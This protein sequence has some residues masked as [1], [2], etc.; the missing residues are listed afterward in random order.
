MSTHPDDPMMI[1]HIDMNFVCLKEDYIRKWLRTLAEMGYNAVLWELEDKVRWETCPECV[2]PEAFPK[3]T[4]RDLLAYSRALG[5]EPIPLLQTIGHAEYVL[6]HEPYRRFREQP[7]RHDCYC[8][9]NPEVRRFL[10]AWIE[11]YLDLFGDLRYFHLG[12]DEAYVFG[13]CPDCRAYTD[14]HSPNHLY[15]D[16]IID[17]AEPIR[18]RGIRPG[19]W[20]DMVLAHPEHIDA[21]PQAFVIWDWNYWSTGADDEGTRL[22]DEGWVTLNT[23]T[24]GQTKR[25]PE[26]LDARGRLRPFYTSDVLQ[27]LGYDVILCSAARSAGDTAFLPNYPRHV[28]NIATAA[29]KART[30]GLL[31]NC[32]TSWAVRLNPYET[33]AL[34][35]GLA[36][37]A[38]SHPGASIPEMIHTYGSQLI[39]PAVDTFTE[40]ASRLSASVP[41]T[42]AG[43]TGIQWNGLK[44]SLPAPEH[45]LRD[46]LAEW[47]DA[48]PRIWRERLEATTQSLDRIREGKQLLDRVLQSLP[49][50]GAGYVEAWAKGAHLQYWHAYV[51][52]QILEDGADQIPVDLMATLKEEFR[53]IQAR[54]EKPQSAAKNAGLVYDV[55]IAYLM[56]GKS[57]L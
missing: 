14:A 49:P 48:Q 21:I 8:T 37:Y 10:K 50:G 33:Q 18:E 57:A 51:A 20:C 6:L 32:V 17:L 4:F 56:E 27:R 22:W 2:W 43:S 40:A 52:K 3:D 35:I 38:A 31:G 54:A 30:A 26:M 15:A 46:L 28:R 45:Y 9:R 23:L 19:I 42:Q 24:E 39:G 29:Q 16:H 25:Y 12:G 1:F 5:L 34:T 7:D 13:T 44:D 36:P 55:V 47:R 41:F 11:E 53:T